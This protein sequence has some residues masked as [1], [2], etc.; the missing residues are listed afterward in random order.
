LLKSV[1]GPFEKYFFV[2]NNF[3]KH[4]DAKAYNRHVATGMIKLHELISV[5]QEV[6]RLLLLENYRGLWLG[7][8]VTALQR[9]ETVPGNE[10]VQTKYTKPS[11][12]RNQWSKE[13]LE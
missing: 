7:K 10:V 4:A 3:I 9:G 6:L 2:I 11:N 8:L 5:G 13:G 1:K 12:E